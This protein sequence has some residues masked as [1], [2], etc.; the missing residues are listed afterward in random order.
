M[1]SKVPAV[2]K[3]EEVIVQPITAKITPPKPE[4]RL[5]KG[6]GNTM[7]L[8]IFELFDMCCRLFGFL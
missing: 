1:F 3:P 6:T 8:P 5:T 2:A 7:S 4:D